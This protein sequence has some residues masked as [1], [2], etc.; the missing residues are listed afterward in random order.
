MG[1]I[2]CSL[3]LQDH[4]NMRNL[5]LL[6][7][8]FVSIYS[9]GQTSIERQLVGSAGNTKTAANLTINYSVGESV[10]STQEISGSLVITQGFQKTNDIE[11]KLDEANIVVNYKIYPNPVVD[12]LFID[13][14]TET[15]SSL[16][17]TLVDM[18]GKVLESA[19]I[20]TN[21]HNSEI[22]IFNMSNY[23]SGIYFVNIADNANKGESI[24][25]V[26]Q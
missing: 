7:L 24:K 25:I 16:L 18:N 26:K 5:T 11:T 14:K 15:N 3:F 2:L 12:N 19:E 9:F 23:K 13:I 17:V 6:I 22:S 8:I 4:N 21:A 10:I 1:Q 20:K